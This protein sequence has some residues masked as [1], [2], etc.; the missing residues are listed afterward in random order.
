MNVKSVCCD[1]PTLK[2][3]TGDVVCVV[4]GEIVNPNPKEDEDVSIS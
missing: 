4:C 3:P 1:A 2:E